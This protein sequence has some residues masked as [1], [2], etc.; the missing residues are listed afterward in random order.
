[1]LNGTTPFHAENRAQ[2]ENKV[3]KSIYNLKE[4]V[5]KNLTLECI[6]FLSQCL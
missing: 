1:M 4:Y 2:F 3:D 5:K 6:L